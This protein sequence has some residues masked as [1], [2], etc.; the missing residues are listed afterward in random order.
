FGYLIAAQGQWI[1]GFLHDKFENF[2]F[3]I[4][5]LVFVGILVNIFGY[6][7]YKSQIIK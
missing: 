2:S 1:I 6:L 7:S 3:A 5:M 4:L